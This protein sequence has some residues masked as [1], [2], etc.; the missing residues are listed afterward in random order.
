MPVNVL[1]SARP[2]IWPD[3]EPLLR[4]YFTEA[5]LDVV[6]ATDLSAAEV[7]YVVYAPS[8][9]LHDF[10]PFT[11]LKAI[12]SLWAGVESITGNPTL[13]VP[14]ARMVDH[15]L[16]QGMTEWVTGHV[17]RHHLGMDAHIV[18]PDHLWQPAPP[19]LASD[20]RVT[21]LGL[22]AL[23]AASAQALANLGFRVTG[24]SRRAK[25]IP[26]ITCL[27]GQAGLDEALKS[28]EIIVLL[29]PDTPA[30]EN[31]LNADRL[32]LPA[33][34]AFVINPGRGPLIDDEALLAALDSGQIGHATLDVFRVEPLP[35][36][37]PYWAHP[38]VTVT[39]HISSETRPVTAAQVIVENIRRGEA[40][41]ALLH[42][43]DRETGY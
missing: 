27:N 35:S 30:T 26:G 23:G 7:D 16:T 11:R 4:R 13:K 22:G 3:Y 43:V 18:N 5:G 32:A 14:L 21:I 36:D 29:L 40:G 37:H 6:L 20:R 9:G 31:T 28:A 17:L 41:E 8:S 2:A 42:L 12:L 1:F 38:K 34:G 19:P 24:W 25:D 39:P 10:T 15:G 33:P